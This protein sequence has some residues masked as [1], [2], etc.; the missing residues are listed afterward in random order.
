MGGRGGYKQERRIKNKE[1][2]EREQWVKQL[3]TM[4]KMKLELT[5]TDRLNERE[6]QVQGESEKE[7]LG[8]SKHK[9]RKA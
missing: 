3:G 7:G 6:R 8:G 2:R 9:T 4:G 1:R 5:T